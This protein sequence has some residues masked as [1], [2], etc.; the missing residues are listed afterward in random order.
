VEAVSMPRVITRLAI[1]FI[2][3]FLAGCSSL[4]PRAHTSTVGPWQNYREAQQAFDK[5]IP[6]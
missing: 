4:L 3:V 1:I 6:Y 2:P 5:I